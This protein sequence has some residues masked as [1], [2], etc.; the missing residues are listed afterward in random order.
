MNEIVI[1]KC[2]VFAS[3][4]EVE[5]H[6]TQFFAWKSSI[7]EVTGATDPHSLPPDLFDHFMSNTPDN[8]G[9]FESPD[10]VGLSVF[11]G[12]MA[13][14]IGPAVDLFSVANCLPRFNGRWN[15][16][17]IGDWNCLRVRDMEGLV[18]HGRFAIPCPGMM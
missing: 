1:Y 6:G 11:R 14:D 8:L 13:A 12:T 9:D 15:D 3:T 7:L 5:Q 10:L 2:V 17:L 16:L 4:H 18:D